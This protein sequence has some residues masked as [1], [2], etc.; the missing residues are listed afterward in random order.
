MVC[1]IR[2]CQRPNYNKG[3]GLWQSVMGGTLKSQWLNYGV[4]NASHCLLFLGQSEFVVYIN[5][6][7]SKQCLFWWE[8]VAHN[9]CSSGIHFVPKMHFV[10]LN[11]KTQSHFLLNL[12][13][14][15]GLSKKIHFPHKIGWRYN[16]VNHDYESSDVSNRETP[17]LLFFYCNFCKDVLL[18]S[19]PLCLTCLWSNP[20]SG[21]FV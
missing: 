16:T 17:N 18:I 11:E 7:W 14:K 5:N 20:K 12:A 6:I 9:K 8:K 21:C 2:R 15:D 13:P 3:Q 19:V 10:S 1:F 4:I